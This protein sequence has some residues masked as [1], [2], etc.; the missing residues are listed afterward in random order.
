MLGVKWDTHSISVYIPEKPSWAGLAIEDAMADWNDAQSWFIQTYFTSVTSA[1]FSLVPTQNPSSAQVEVRYVNDTG[2]AWG[3]N[4]EVP[5]SGT[6]TN[7]TVLIV[8]SRLPTPSD[9]LQVIQHEFGHV[10]GLDHTA[11]STDLMYPAMDS[12][13]GGEPL[14]PSTLN[15]YGVYLLGIGCTFSG[16]AVAVLPSQIPYLEWFPDI[17]QE[18]ANESY[19]PVNTIENQQVANSSCPRVKELWQQPSFIFASLLLLVALGVILFRSRRRKVPRPSQ[20]LNTF[21]DSYVH[22]SELG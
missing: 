16:G 21:D 7:E 14:H 6:I 18:L 9:L 12:Y 4:T 13:L 8:L 17:Q 2:Q 20:F 3:G 5:A 19:A 10:L 22:W 1:E 15:L 11:I